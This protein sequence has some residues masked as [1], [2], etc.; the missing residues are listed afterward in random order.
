MSNIDGLILAVHYE[1]AKYENLI[2]RIQY[3]LDTDEQDALALIKIASNAHRAEM[4]LA[5]L[6]RKLRE[7]FE[8]EVDITSTG[9]PNAAM[10]VIQI[11]G[12]VS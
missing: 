9:G 12:E 11:I 10:R 2:T 1:L 7:E 3:A 6:K 4:E 8:D 5:T